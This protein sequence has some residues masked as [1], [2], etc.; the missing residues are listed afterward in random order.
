VI[1]ERRFEASDEIIALARPTR[2]GRHGG[3]SLGIDARGDYNR[4]AV[5]LAWLGAGS[6]GSAAEGGGARGVGDMERLKVLCFAGTYG[7]ALASELARFVV[8]NPARWYAT[9]G[10]TALGWLVQTVFLANLAWQSHQI[11][12]TTVFE[13]LLVLSWILAAICLYLMVHSR[14]QVAVGVFL[15]PLVLGLAIVAGEYAPRQADW[16]D[17]GGAVAFWGTVHGLFLLAGAVFT[18]VAFAA[19]LMYLVQA[20]RLKQKRPPRFGFALPSLEQSERLNRGM[21]ILA[22]PLLTF[23][24]VIGLVLGLGARGGSGA[25]L[26]WTDPK[27]VSASVMWLVFAVLLHARFRPALRGRGVML[28]TI[29]AFAFLVFTWVGVEALHLPTAHGVPRTAGRSL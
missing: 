7:L 16:G 14:K 20:N 12:I 4:M 22:F 9:V 6:V 29:V 1:A 5:R 17:W 28:L 11:P 24:L 26:G 21:I 18:C 2:I 25:H 10:L 19:G 3:G 27:V 15:L 23:G 8:R 13:S